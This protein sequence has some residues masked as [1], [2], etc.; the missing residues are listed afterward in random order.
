MN[1]TV[2]TM[3]G[4][5]ATEIWHGQTA[6][7]Q[8][9]AS[10]RLASTSRRFDR[11]RGQWVD[12]D[13]LYFTVVCHRQLAEHVT[14]S[15][16]KGDPMIVYGRLNQR[17]W[18]SDDGRSGVAAEIDAYGIGHDLNKGTSAFQRAP[19]R[20]SS[21][22]SDRVVADDLA[23]AVARQPLPSADDEVAAAADDEVAA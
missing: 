15:C 6:S 3:A 18:Q 16:A 22:E 9:V 4:N 17:P 1:E 21:E 14:S 7:G 19:R 13:T 8:A 11:S 20:A 23:L 5:I 10:F 2:T 12:R